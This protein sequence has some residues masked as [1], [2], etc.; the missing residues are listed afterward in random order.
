MILFTQFKLMFTNL[1]LNEEVN[2]TRYRH[3]K[4]M[5]G[6]FRNPFNRG[7]VHNILEYWHL[8]RNPL[9]LVQ[10]QKHIL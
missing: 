7:L 8:K 5:D 2:Y 3:F 6:R 4:T 10:G 1:T 9:I